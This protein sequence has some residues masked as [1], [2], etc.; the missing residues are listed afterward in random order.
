MRKYALLA[1]MALLLTPAAY[2]TGFLMP[3]DQRFCG[4]QLESHRVTVDIE[5]QSARTEV[6]EVFRNQHRSQ[7]E[8]TFVFP[9]PKD[10]SVSHFKMYVNGKLVTGEIMEATKARRIYEDIVARQ[11]DPGLL[12]YM[13]SRILKLSVFPIL[14]NT[15]QEVRI[16]YNE[17]LQASDSLVE[18]VYP[19]KTPQ[20]AATTL[21]DFTLTVN[22]SASAGVK[23]VY[24][25][26]H[27]VVVHY[28][29]DRHATAGFEKTAAALDTDFQLF[30]EISNKDFGAALLST[31]RAGNDGYFM[32]LLSPRVDVPTAAVSAKDVVFVID[33]SGSMRDDK[34]RQA[35]KALEVCVTN[36]NSNDRFNIV[37][38]N[39]TVEKFADALVDANSNYRD[40][41]LKFIAALSAAGGT[42]IDEALTEA[43]AMKRGT[44]RPFV[45]VFL[46]D[47]LPTVGKTDID[48]ILD[49]VARADSSGTRIFSFGVGYDVNTT[50][51]DKLA[52]NTKAVSQYVEPNEAIDVKVSS[53][54]KRIGDPVLSRIEVNFGDAGV[55]D[56]YPPHAGDLFLG[57]QLVLT[58]RYRRPGNTTIVVRGRGAAGEL[59]FEYPVEFSDA[60][61]KADFVANVW[62][63]RK[64][65]FLLREMRLHGEKG[66]LKDEVIR[67]SREFGIVTPY[68]SYLVTEGPVGPPGIARPIPPRRRWYPL[69]GEPASEVIESRVRQSEARREAG[70]QA[71]PS[72]APTEREEA[73]KSLGYMGGGKDAKAGVVFSY[74]APVTGEDAVKASGAYRTLADGAIADKGHLMRNVAGRLFVNVDGVWVDSSVK[75]DQILLKIKFGGTEYFEMYQNA[76]S[77]KEAFA[78]GE[79]VVIS[80]GHYCLVIGEETA[81][82]DI[83]D[84]LKAV[85]KAFGDLK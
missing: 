41:A 52:E 49:D 36:L 82:G 10:A 61:G 72:A 70:L 24:S 71:A 47:G 64:I 85:I 84:D 79:N 77:L 38:F 76:A 21:N 23:N 8:A 74:V 75:K 15:T 68:T 27:D 69:G 78:L 2:G 35:R 11:R 37:T 26:T 43:L 5:D 29:D 62:A 57:T 13:D 9:L 55:Y 3:T 32:L 18:Y 48:G 60:Q 33:T 17:Q 58:G 50:L 44:E 39:T 19:L 59:V 16:T 42:N 22:I 45:V 28:K 1:V 66:E 20:A 12:E 30:Y 46:T 31:R 40:E 54:F 73:L 56:A 67:L 4:L 63:G 7:L 83:K 14:P 81:E 6:V 53:F 25:P 65:A 34:I 80:V 51:L